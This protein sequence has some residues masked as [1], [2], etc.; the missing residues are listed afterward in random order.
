[1]EINFETLSND[2]KLFNRVQK[3]LRRQLCRFLTISEFEICYVLKSDHIQIKLTRASEN[4]EILMKYNVIQGAKDCAMYVFCQ[5]LRNI[6]K[7]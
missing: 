6:K 5:E 1:M 3:F 2:D 4:F 7:I